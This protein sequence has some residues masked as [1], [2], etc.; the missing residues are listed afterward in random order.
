MRCEGSVQEHEQERLQMETMLE[1]SSPG[2]MQL[3]VFTSV[4]F[5]EYDVIIK[6]HIIKYARGQ[7]LVYLNRLCVC[8]FISSLL[9]S[10]LFDKFYDFTYFLRVFLQATSMQTGSSVV[11][12]SISAR[13]AGFV[14]LFLDLNI[15]D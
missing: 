3:E 12:L 7:P 8:A 5:S 1:A 6:E 15:S 4:N 2:S 10:S 9:V 14:L 11:G 13:H